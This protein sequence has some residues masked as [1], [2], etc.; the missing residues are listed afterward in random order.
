LA[1]F[2]QE[3]EVLKTTRENHREKDRIDGFRF[4]AK[5]GHFLGRKR[6]CNK[7]VQ[8]GYA[9]GKNDNEAQF[10]QSVVPIM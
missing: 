7:D 6:C 3:A 9:K 8:K 5:E 4:T 10:K 2:W 1:W